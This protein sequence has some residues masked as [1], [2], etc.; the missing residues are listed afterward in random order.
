MQFR[1]PVFGSLWGGVSQGLPTNFGLNDPSIL[2]YGV[3]VTNRSRNGM[4]ITYTDTDPRRR[5]V[6]PVF[7][8][9]TRVRMTLQATG[10]WFVRGT[11][12]DSLGS[13]GITTYASNAA[14]T[15]NIDFTVLNN[16]DNWMGILLNSINMS[17]IITNFRAEYPYPMYDILT[18]HLIGR[19]DTL[20]NSARRSLIDSRIIA[21]KA[22]TWYP[23]LDALWVHA[24]HGAE[25]G[26]LNW[27]SKRFNCVPV[28]NPTFVTDR[29]YTGD[30]IS[31]Y[32]NTQFNP[33]VE[34]PLGS[35]YQQ[36]SVTFGIRINDNTSAAGSI[37]GF[38]N[39]TKGTTIQPGSSGRAGGRV[40]TSTYF[41]SG[42]GAVMNSI[43]MYMITR[44]GAAT[45]LLKQGSPVASSGASS[46]TV[47][48][49]NLRLGAIADDNYR[50]GQFSMGAIGGGMT[51]VELL[52]MFNWFQP[53]REAV[54]ISNA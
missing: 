15:Y 43:G 29:G 33:A 38:Y 23:K 22:T 53:Y 9:G 46:A 2:W 20:P 4:T 17:V 51:D 34:V 19:F 31:S 26:R 13:A 32:L 45:R 39:G 47:A 36:D 42:A 7:P 14:G 48:D 16:A 30:G 54:G 3:D 37:A 11:P 25:A 44:N 5:V 24:A 35:K 12:D 41:Q 27:I 50:A 21:L 6:W 10:N 49:G 8:A 18:Q 1:Y 52:D 28:N 40:N